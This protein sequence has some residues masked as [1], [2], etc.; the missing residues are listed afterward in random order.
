MGD[1]LLKSR[2]GN[3]VNEDGIK[4]H[5]QMYTL[6]VISATA[7]AWTT[8]NSEA[9]VYS[10]SDGA[11]GVVWRMSFNITGLFASPTS[12]ASLDIDDI[13]FASLGSAGGQTITSYQ[14]QNTTT[15]YTSLAEA[16]RGGN[17]IISYVNANHQV[18]GFTADVTLAS[19]PTFVA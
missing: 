11:G 6:T 18:F 2:S 17:N 13:T 10:V 5:S 16:S 3:V 19:K 1:R 14:N 4:F 12:T 7:N 8:R 9:H 15:T